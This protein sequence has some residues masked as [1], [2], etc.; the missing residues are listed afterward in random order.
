ML[1]N[2]KKL[3]RGSLLSKVIVVLMVPIIARI[4]TPTDIGIAALFTSTLMIIS[5]L[6]NLRYCLAVPLPKREEIADTLVLVCVLSSTI[7]TLAFLFAVMIDGRS[8]FKYLGLLSIYDYRFILIF[9]CFAVSI[10]ETL[11]MWVVRKKEFTRYSN[12]LIK[13]SII[14]SLVKIVGGFVGLNALGIIWG[15]VVQNTAGL[16]Q[17]IIMYYSNRKNKFK[18]SRQKIKLTFFYYL[19]YLYFKFPAHFLYVVSAQLPIIYVSRYYSMADVGYLSLAVSLLSIPISAISSSVSKVYFSEMSSLGKNHPKRIYKETKSILPK[20]LI[21]G[22]II[23]VLAFVF[24]PFAFSLFL[25]ED[26]TDAGLISRALSIGLVFQISATTL[27]TVLNVINL[28]FLSFF[29]HLTRFTITFFSFYISSILSLDLVT[30]IYTYSFSLCMFYCLVIVLV[31][32]I[33]KIRSKNNI[34]SGVSLN[35]KT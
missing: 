31:M 3:I 21:V 22:I 14:G 15:I 27:I 23:S 32:Y 25:G 20:L 30:S 10:Y 4:Y 9:A 7:F 35:G 17:F 24:S 29:I 5:P 1:Q 2:V 18:I 6:I 19:N 34:K 8:L 26:W 33:L 12:V 28:N 11:S 13:Q 16:L